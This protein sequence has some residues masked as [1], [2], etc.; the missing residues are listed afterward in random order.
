MPRWLR[1]RP[2]FAALG[3]VIHLRGFSTCHLHWYP[4][5]THFDLCSYDAM[6]WFLIVLLRL[7]DEIYTICESHYCVRRRL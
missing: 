5:L 3:P 6:R 2:L 7:T 4:P 1:G